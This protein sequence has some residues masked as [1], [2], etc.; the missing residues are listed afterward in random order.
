[1]LTRRVGTFLLAVFFVTM[2]AVPQTLGTPVPEPCPNAG[3]GIKVLGYHV[4]WRQWTDPIARIP[5]SH[6]T[7]LSYFA[8]MANPNGS[9]GATDGWSDITF[10]SLAGAVAHTGVKVGM[11]LV[12]WNPPDTPDPYGCV[13]Q[14]RI[15]EV[16][17]PANH[18][19][20]INNIMDK[21]NLAG[22]DGV[23]VDIEFP[24]PP[25]YDPQTNPCPPNT[26]DAQN[27]LDFVTALANRVHADI[28]GSY[29]YVAVPQWDYPH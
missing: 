8:V 4:S 28:S 11:T 19:T 29:V 3:L 7:N 14:A 16:L 18:A 10:A 24:A 15:H 22:A 1:M 25:V 26:Q 6:L 23:D 21:L 2:L 5:W 17:N 20:L 27:Y 9:L 13:L 12:V